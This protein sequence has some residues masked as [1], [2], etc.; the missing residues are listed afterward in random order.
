MLT[1]Q[2]INGICLGSMYA[3]VAL[4]FTLVIGV[5]DK[6]NFALPAL[7]VL[8]GFTGITVTAVV[9]T[10]W[11]AALGTVVAGGLV[12]MIVG[13]SSFARARSAEAGVAASLSSLALGLMI[14]DLV[15]HRWGSDPVMLSL[16]SRFEEGGFNLGATRLLPIQLL[17]LATSFALVA[18]LYALVGHTAIGRRIRAVADSPID[19]GRHGINTQLVAHIVFFLSGALVAVSG[20]LFALRVGSASTDTGLPIGFKALAIMAIGGMGDLP[21]AI[22]GGLLIGVLES[23]GV[24]AGFGRMSE[25]SVWATMILVLL[26][27]P[28]GL[29]GRGRGLRDQRV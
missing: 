16:A 14:L 27:R 12:G 17:I 29:F 19:A 13:Y 10:F 28:K 20:L 26:V 15:R 6:L 23:L 1:A 11:A 18:A 25:L 4:G 7:F 22:I 8:G 21:G 24:Y 3:L 5:F 9:P 2:I